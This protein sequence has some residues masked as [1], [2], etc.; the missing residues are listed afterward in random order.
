MIGGV[1]DFRFLLHRLHIYVRK[2]H[3][4]AD[5][6]TIVSMICHSMIY[7]FINFLRECPKFFRCMQILQFYRNYFKPLGADY[8]EN[9]FKW[10]DE[11]LEVCHCYIQWL[12]PLH[13]EVSKFNHHSQLITK[14]ESDL[15]CKNITASLRVM[16]SFEK[17]LSFWGFHLCH[18]TWKI[19]VKDI[20]RLNFLNTSFHNFLRIT[21]VLKSMPLLGLFVLRQAFIDALKEQVFNG[22]LLNAYDSMVKYWLPL[23]SVSGNYL[24]N[25]GLT[26]MMKLDMCTQISTCS[27]VICSSNCS[28]AKIILKHFA[29]KEFYTNVFSLKRVWLIVGEKESN[30]ILLN[31]DYLRM[32]IV[33]KDCLRRKFSFF[34]CY[35]G[36]DLDTW[37][38]SGLWFW[39][40]LSVI[41]V[42]EVCRVFSNS[43]MNQQKFISFVFLIE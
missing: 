41:E 16:H 24:Q 5:N 22:T 7:G 43:Y 2:L 38:Y 3:D 36:V 25:I 42:D 39:D 21:R 29:L 15:I 31:I 26:L 28:Y 11:R 34:L 35:P 37:N 8:I 9:I 6:N 27:Q 40:D 30:M 20:N 32:K 18:S 10:D 19:Y 33:A 14:Q 4:D 12:F 1:I 23:Q 13:D 17:I